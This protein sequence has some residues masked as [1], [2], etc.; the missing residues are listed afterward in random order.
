MVILVREDSAKLT[1][2][3][4]HALMLEQTIVHFG[5]IEGNK[6]KQLLPKYRGMIKKECRVW[7]RAS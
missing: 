6:Y 2:C 1:V 7:E 4:I 5:I 3:L